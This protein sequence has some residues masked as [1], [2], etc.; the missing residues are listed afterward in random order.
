VIEGKETKETEGTKETKGTTSSSSTGRRKLITVDYVNAEIRDVIRALA[1]QSGVNLALNPDVKGSVTVH[2]RDKTVDEAIVMTANLAGLAAKKIKE[3]FVIAPRNEM[4]ATMER[5][6]TSRRVTVAHLDARAAADIAQN[7]FPDLTAKLDGSAADKGVTLIGSEEDIRDAAKLIEQQDVIP[8]ESVRTVEKFALRFIAAAQAVSAAGKMVPGVT[9]DPAGEAVVLTGTKAQVDAAKSGL[10][11]LDVQKQ[12]DKETRI[13]NIRYSQPS[14]LITIVERTMPDVNVYPGPDSHAPARPSFSP[15]SGQFVGMAPGTGG[16]GGSSNSQS[17]NSGA[18]ANQ[19]GQQN[20][21]A[22]SPNAQLAGNALSLILQGSPAALDEAMKVLAM[23]DVAPRQMMIEAKVVETNPSTAEELGVKWSWTRFGM[24]ETKAGT[25]IDT[26]STGGP[27]GDFTSF[28]TKNVGPGVFSRVP[29]SFQAVLSAMITN[30]TAKLLANPQIS[31]IND[32]DASI[33]I[34][35]TLRF[36]SLATSSPTT[37]SQFTV[38]EVPVGIILLCHPRINGDNDITLRLHPVVS[39]VTALINGLPQTSAR[40]AETVVRV[41]DG[42]T[43]V[44]GG[45]IRDEDIREMTK[46]PFLADLP[47]VG[48]LFRHSSK[49]HRRTEV[50]VVITVHLLK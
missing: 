32:Q 1:A 42:D 38:V 31:V 25:Q 27:G 6:G 12:P 46:V 37:G 13:Y 30:R 33:F 17:A 10:A 5:L 22:Q 34:G 20:A 36:Q 19:N 7:S 43:L 2:L 16:S 45:L 8:A 39:T 26:G 47:L 21:A 3:T 49:Q 48:H 40:E 18:M 44:I 35:D 23:A 50:M 28:N 4:R 9:A 15:L 41:K 29:F 24:Y 11:L 14:Q